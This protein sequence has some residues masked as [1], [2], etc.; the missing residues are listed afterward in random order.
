MVWVVSLEGLKRA[1]EASFCFLLRSPFRANHVC[2]V[3]QVQTAHQS[4]TGFTWSGGSG[5][6]VLWRFGFGV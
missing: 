5:V 6:F 2:C 1:S 4:M 3:T